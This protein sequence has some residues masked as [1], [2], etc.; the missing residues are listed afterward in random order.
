[1]ISGR[2]DDILPSPTMDLIAR[3]DALKRE[4]IDLVDLGAGQ[5]DFPVPAP[6]IEA[7]TEALREG[8]TTYGPAG[9][10]P[11]L[12]EAVARRYNRIHGGAYG[13]GNVLI[14]SGAKGALTYALGALVNPGDEVVVPSPYFVSY[15]YQVLLWGGVPRLMECPESDRFFPTPERLEAA[16][17]PKTRGLLLNS[18]HNP[19]GAVLSREALEELLDLAAGRGLFVILD[20]VYNRFVYGGE[21]AASISGLQPDPEDGRAFFVVGS[22]A[23]TFSMTGYRVGFLLGPAEAVAAATR[24]Q[25][26]SITAVATFAQYGAVEALNREDE[27][28]APYIDEYAG[29]RTLLMDG[30]ASVPGMEAKEAPGAFFVFPNVGRILVERGMASVN[31]LATYLLEEARVITVPG[32]AFGA[33]GHL[34][35]SFAASRPAIEEGLLRM[36]AALSS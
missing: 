22:C 5:P 13:S 17:G 24:L 31:D 20:D 30:L 29:R 33:E 26:H 28:I 12:R 2:L 16:I 9:G 18:P 19:T 25:A 21:T 32:T 7:T 23:K 15:P 36:A 27:L 4:G 3:V 35:I 1:M 14:G 11:P 6:V 8:K 10:I 34:R